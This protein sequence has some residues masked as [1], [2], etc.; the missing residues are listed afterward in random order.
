MKDDFNLCFIS[1]N[2]LP[3]V[4]F[5]GKRPEDHLQILNDVIAT[6]KP[7]LKADV[8]ASSRDGV[9]EEMRLFLMTH[10]CKCLPSDEDGFRR[11]ESIYPVLHWVLSEY[12]NLRKRT[13]LSRYLMSVD[14]PMEYLSMQTNGNLEELLEAYKELQEEVRIRRSLPFSVI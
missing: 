13:Y 12:E 4:D 8:R 6:L 9:A 7:D 10:K 11:K 2:L 1:L 14:V 3:Q 5:D